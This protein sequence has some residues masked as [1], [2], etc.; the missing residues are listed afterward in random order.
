MKLGTNTLVKTMTKFEVVRL[1]HESGVEDYAIRKTRSHWLT[2]KPELVYLE[3]CYDHWGW[4]RNPDRAET[5][6]TAVLA[7]CKVDKL[8]LIE[9][10]K[11]IK[12]EVV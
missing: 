4:T 1:T 2:R 9:G 10:R 11:V 8:Q 6:N 3:D 7:Q 5:F 12:I